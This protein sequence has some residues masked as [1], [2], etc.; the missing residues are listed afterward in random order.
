MVLLLIDFPFRVALGVPPLFEDA[1]AYADYVTKTSGSTLTI[2]VID[3]FMMACVLVFLAGFRH[4]IHKARADCEWVGTLVFG[5]GLAL[6][7]L[8]LV[9]DALQGGAALDT[10]V[11]VDPAGEPGLNI[12]QA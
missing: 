4:L 10:F 1:T 8:E 5:T 2:I 7:T 3:M 11:R 12:G 9:G 6:I